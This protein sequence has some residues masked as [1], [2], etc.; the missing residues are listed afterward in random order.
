MNRSV[1]VAATTAMAA[2]FLV[3]A[4]PAMAVPPTSERIQ[5][6]DSF[7]DEFLT[8]ECGVPVTTSLRGH[9]T[10]KTFDRDRGPTELTN[11]N[12]GFTATAGGRTFRFRDVGSDLTR[13]TRDGT[14]VLRISGQVPYDFAG[15]LKID[16]GTGA[17]ILEPKD[18]SAKQLARACAVLAG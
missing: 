18:R 17:A 8:E 16:L 10:I 1:R 15:T 9:V 14:A 3:T 5:V 2:A 7:A 11:I 6:N 13:I 12:I 4:A